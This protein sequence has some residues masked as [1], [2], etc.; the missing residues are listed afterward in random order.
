MEHVMTDF[1]PLLALT[2]SADLLGTA[3]SL[4]VDRPRPTASSRTRVSW[5]ERVDRWFEAQ[6]R[7]S[8]DAW[9]AQSQ[10][11]F[12]LE[13]RIRELERATGSRYY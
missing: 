8:R 10:D 13:R 5:L 12:E 9:L 11:V 7:R 6:R 1:F 3:M 2:R 4:P